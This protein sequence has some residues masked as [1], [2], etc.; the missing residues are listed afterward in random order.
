M[1]LT[2]AAQLTVTQ[3]LRPFRTA[4]HSPSQVQGS[5]ASEVALLCGG[6]PRPH[7][8]LLLYTA[9]THT[10]RRL[11][12]KP[13]HSGHG[14]SSPKAARRAVWGQDSRKASEEPRP[15][16]GAPHPC[17]GQ[18]GRGLGPPSSQV[19]RGLSVKTT[20]GA[21]VGELRKLGF[22]TSQHR[23]RAKQHP[24]TFQQGSPS[25]S[26]PMGPITPYSSSCICS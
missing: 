20:G 19:L 26:L 10:G 7:G 1:C 16:P 6:R 24:D 22:I 15:P 18:A 9:A 14:S 8:E 11:C 21:Q 13:N 23:T 2:P 4:S 12:A 25:S 3:C 5:P 17:E